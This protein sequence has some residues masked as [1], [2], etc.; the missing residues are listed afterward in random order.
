MSFDPSVVCVVG[1][2]VQEA[3]PVEDR[4]AQP[5]GEG[6]RDETLERSAGHQHAAGACGQTLP[7]LQEER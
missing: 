4:C 3:L 5:E 2:S 7:G 6:V 1:A